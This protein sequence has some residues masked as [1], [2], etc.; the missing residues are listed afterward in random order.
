MMKMRNLYVGKKSLIVGVSALMTLL[1]AKDDKLFAQSIKHAKN[2]VA[3]MNV[4]AANLLMDVDNVDFSYL[5]DA[6]ADKAV[7]DYV[8][9]VK[10]QSGG[11]VRQKGQ[12]RL[13]E[14]IKTKIWGTCARISW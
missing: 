8:D 9:T 1:M 7:S 5:I 2:Q 11:F 4:N 13:Y 6:R 14:S 10:K 3:S 12:D